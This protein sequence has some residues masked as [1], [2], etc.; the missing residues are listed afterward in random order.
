MRPTYILALIVLLR[1][2][3]ALNNVR[4]VLAGRTPGFPLTPGGVEQARTAA[5]MLRPLGISRIY[6]S[7]MERARQTAEIASAETSASVKL[8]DRLLELEMGSFTGMRYVDIEPEYGNVF[9]KYYMNSPELEGA[10]IESFAEV[11]RR[12][13]SMTDHV[14]ESHPAENTLLVTHMDPI[15]AMIAN[16][17]GMAPESL[18]RLIIANASLNVFAHHGDGVYLKGINVLDTARFNDDW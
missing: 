7:P 3:Q 6:C 12:V 4:R 11:R 1:H 16:V 10:G 17:A 14:L 8:D 2:G 5:G 13:A 18:Y 9:E 15:K